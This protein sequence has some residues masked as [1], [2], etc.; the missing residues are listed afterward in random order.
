MGRFL[1]AIAL[2]LVS[3]AAF[4]VPP[5]PGDYRLDGGPDVVGGLR[6]SKDG[7]FEYWLIAGALDEQAKGRWEQKDQNIRLFTEPKPKPPIFTVGAQVKED[8]A[9]FTLLVT[10]PNGE[11]I[12][13]VDFRIGFDHGEPATGYTQY[14]GWSQSPDD[15]RTPLWVE[16]VEPIHAIISPRYAI[17]AAKGNKLTFILTPNDLGT[18]DFDGATVEATESGLVLHRREGDMPF[19]KAKR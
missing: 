12:G 18:V 16:L 1:W 19:S 14:Y 2:L 7:R 9:P 4:A 10:W 13:G 5:A 8:T 6:L 11:G 3:T 17:D 15:T